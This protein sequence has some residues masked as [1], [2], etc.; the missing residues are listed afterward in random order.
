M[1]IAILGA[2]G[3][4]GSA[5]AKRLSNQDLV[6]I[7]NYSAKYDSRP[8][9]KEVEG[10]KI[11]NGDLA[12]IR[13][14]EDRLR[15]VEII[16]HLAA[17]S[18]ISRCENTESYYSNIIA[19]SNVAIWAEKYEAKKI[20]FASTSAVYGEPLRIPIDEAHPTARP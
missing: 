3:Y 14:C 5:L 20:V 2:A 11:I 15:G 8:E 6:L 12:D 13:V 16:Y 9:I 18:G 19:T 10:H 4:I 7:D 17:L 1:K